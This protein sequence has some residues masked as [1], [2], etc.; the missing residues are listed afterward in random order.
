MSPK[1]PISM[2][3]RSIARFLWEFIVLGVVVSGSIFL[4][5]APAIYAVVR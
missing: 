2:Q 1:I 3:Q 5:V 4:V